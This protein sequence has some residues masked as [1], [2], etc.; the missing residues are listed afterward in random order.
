MVS[1]QF[2]PLV[3]S[4]LLVFASPCLSQ[5]IVVFMGLLKSLIVDALLDHITNEVLLFL[6]DGIELSVNYIKLIAGILIFMLKISN[7]FFE[8][9]P[10]LFLFVY[11][12]LDFISSG[13]SLLN[14]IAFVFSLKQS[15]LEAIIDVFQVFGQLCQQE[16]HAV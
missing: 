2:I 9:P 8:H 3:F 14:F 12:T 5:L 13:L 7:L 6:L 15:T 1:H 11:L 16:G 4:F 10:F